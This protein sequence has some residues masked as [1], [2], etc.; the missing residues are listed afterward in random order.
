[1]AAKVYWVP[2]LAEL[3]VFTVSC[4]SYDPT[5]LLS[6]ESFVLHCLSLFLDTGRTISCAEID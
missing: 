4:I 1:M 3:I 5:L 2:G 6:L